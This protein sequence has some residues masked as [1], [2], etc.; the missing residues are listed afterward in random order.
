MEAVFCLLVFFYTC[1]FVHQPK[2]HLLA[3][4]GVNS[5]AGNDHI[6]E[7][8]GFK[9]EVKNYCRWILRLNRPGGPASSSRTCKEKRFMC[10]PAVG[11]DRKKCGTETETGFLSVEESSPLPEESILQL[12][13]KTQT[14]FLV[15]VL[16]IVLTCLCIPVLTGRVV[17]LLGSCYYRITW[18]CCLLL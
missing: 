6:I 4:D 17:I 14:C 11:L 5:F 1:Y 12:S 7:D 13:L 10:F 8:P 3:C 15:L 9:L 16:L 18:W 2:S